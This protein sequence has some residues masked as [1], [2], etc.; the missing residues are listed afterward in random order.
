MEPMFPGATPGAFR[1]SRRR[2][3][4][5]G[6]FV[7]GAML[8]RDAALFTDLYE[9]TMAASYFRERMSGPATF[10]LFARTLPRG[11]EDV[12]NFL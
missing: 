4:A 2:T 10:S 3:K 12:L 1:R 11:L 9:I 7:S 5:R 6:A 8:T